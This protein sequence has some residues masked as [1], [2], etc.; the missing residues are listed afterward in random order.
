VTITTRI[1]NGATTLIVGVVAL[2]AV[3]A[4]AGLV[5]GFRAEPVLSGSMAP[6]MPI[7]SAAIVK[8]VPASTIVPGDV[9]TFSDPTDPQRRIT[10]RI[11]HLIVRPG[12][13]VLYTTKGDANPTADPWQLRLPGQVGRR[14]VVVPDLGYALHYAGTRRLRS[15]LMA[16]L[17]F[18]LLIG[19]L[20]AIW[21]TPAS[22]A[23]EAARVS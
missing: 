23:P 3:V 9:V 10:H 13:Q 21:R 4:A 14:V 22:P 18:G 7:G 20:R 6:K 2:A 11:Q 15:M 5:L 8:E 19:V 12:G 17:C 16:L 1:V